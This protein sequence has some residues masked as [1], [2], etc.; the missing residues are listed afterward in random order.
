MGFFQAI[1]TC[2][3]KY[4]AFSGRA[5]RPEY[6]WFA[7]FV[8]LGTVV[9]SLIDSAVFGTGPEAGS[10]LASAFQL[11]MFVPLLAAGWRRLQDSGRPGWWILLPMLASIVF[12]V[13]LLGGVMVFA[14]IERAGAD[15]ETLRG[16]AAL[17]GVTGMTIAGIVQLVL[18]V[19]MIWWLTRP[20][21][22]AENVYGPQPS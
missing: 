15:A 8:V 5:S 14:G 20:S 3:R 11:A 13:G 2:L 17:L 18:A 21:E 6:W 22:A 4:L 10:P 12:I 9:F 16:P 1:K 7:L 19:L